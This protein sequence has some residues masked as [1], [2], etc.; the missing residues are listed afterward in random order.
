[1]TVLSGTVIPQDYFWG[2]S[3]LKK[4]TYPDNITEIGAG[5]FNGCSGLSSI[6]LPDTLKTI[7]YSAFRGCSTAE[8][9]ELVLPESVTSIGN[10]AFQNCQKLISVTV[11]GV[12]ETTLGC[13]VFTDCTGM[14]EAVL[15]QNV[16]CLDTEYAYW[17]GGCSALEKLTIPAFNVGV[18]KG[19]WTLQDLFSGSG[20]VPDTLTDVT[21]L[22]GTVIPQDYFWGLS[23]LVSVT[24]SAELE[25]VEANA[26]C[27]CTSLAEAYLIGD[28][29]D[30]DKVVISETGNQP[31]LD[32]VRRGR[33]IVILSDLHDVT[34]EEGQTAEFS[35]YAA[36]KNELTYLW[37]YS[38]DG[39]SNWW[40]KSGWYNNT[41]SFTAL[42]GGYMYR[43]EVRD[44]FGNS[45]RSAEVTLT[46][47]EKRPVPTGKQAPHV[48]GYNPGDVNGDSSIDVSD[49]VLVARFAIG[50]VSATIKD[51]GV[52]NGDVNGDGN[53]D[54]QDVTTILM[55]IAKRIKAFPVSLT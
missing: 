53:T 3:R 40:T 5:A 32:I 30:W 41:L 47:T 38:T 18:K 6:P 11:P 48:P 1:M 36:G 43:C 8:F 14:K 44:G 42:Q 19:E 16:K 49:A 50:D 51:I 9:G 54:I 13:N 20:S 35:I 39:G 45:L 26:F 27:G 7:G 15:G 17:F 37:Q 29:S 55:Y 21:V 12:N 22:S 23:C 33:P 4:V 28:D 10:D 24:F 46:V 34:V 25:T 52:I 2:L 31:L